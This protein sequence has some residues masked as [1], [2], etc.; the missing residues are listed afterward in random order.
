MLGHAPLRHGLRV[1]TDGV[2]AA[3]MGRAPQCPVLSPVLRS[4]TDHAE[5][6]TALPADE[7]TAREVRRRC[8]TWSTSTVSLGAPLQLG[9]DGV[10]KRLRNDAQ[11]RALE[12]LHLL[13]VAEAR[14]PR[15][16]PALS[17]TVE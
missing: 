14:E 8:G 6:G 13:G 10:P 12:H 2:A 15:L 16:A 1:G 4:L 3:L 7:K 11:I 17:A 9:L 5:M